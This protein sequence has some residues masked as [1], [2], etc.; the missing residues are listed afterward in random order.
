M[1]PKRNSNLIYGLL[2]GVWVLVVA[3]QIEEH[4]R[5]REAAR[6]DWRK[7]SEDF[8]ISIGAVVRGQ[9]FRG[10]VFRTQL[11]PILDELVAS[12]TNGLATGE[13]ISIAM[14]NSTNGVMASA[15][16]TIDLEQTDILQAG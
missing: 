4:I 2:L 6:A 11:E 16:R 13:V 12:E 5:V 7:R 9:Q 8:A 3:W 15:G 1:Q 10:A 14:L